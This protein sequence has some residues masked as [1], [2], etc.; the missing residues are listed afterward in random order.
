M[1]HFYTEDTSGNLLFFYFQ[2]VGE[3][4]CS[5]PSEIA[6]DQMCRYVAVFCGIHMTA[7]IYPSACPILDVLAQL[8]INHPSCIQQVKSGVDIR[9]SK[10]RVLHGQLHIAR[11]LLLVSWRAI[12]VRTYLSRVNSRRRCT[13]RVA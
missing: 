10:L 5:L 13:V 7:Y 6:N 8:Y 12:P 11:A 4:R 1:I 9:A 2:L 3:R